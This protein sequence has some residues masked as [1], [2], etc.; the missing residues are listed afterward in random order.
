MSKVTL[1]RNTQKIFRL[2]SAQIRLSAKAV[3][4]ATATSGTPSTFSGVASV[5]LA[6]VAASN[7]S[8]LLIVPVKLLMV[9]RAPT[10]SADATDDVGTEPTLRSFVFAEVAQS[11]FENTEPAPT[12][13]TSVKLSS[14]SGPFGVVSAK[15]A[16]SLWR[17]TD[18]ARES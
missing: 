15:K 7:G 1:R 16:E 17:A 18:R 5:T 4:S 13:C 10:V 6:S 9:D 11:K 14:P 2:S 12:V 3:Q 8:L